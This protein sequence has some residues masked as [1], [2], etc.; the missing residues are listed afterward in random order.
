MKKKLNKEKLV[1]KEPCEMQFKLTVD[2]DT[3]FD[4]ISLIEADVF[5]SIVM[6]GRGIGKTENGNGFVL[7]E[8]KD[9]GEEFIYLR[10]YKSE[11]KGCDTLLDKWIDDVVT[12]P[13]GNGGGTF[14]WHQ[15]RLGWFIPLSIHTRYKSGYD[16]SKVKY[17]I[18]D[19][20]IIKPTATDRYLTDEVTQ[21]LEFIS[22]VFRH[23]TDG[24]VI[25][26]GNNLIFFNPYC[27]F[28]K[29][30]VFNGKYIDRAKGIQVLYSKDSSKLRAIE[31]NTPLF[32]LTKGT[33]YHDYH[34]NNA[35]MSNSKVSISEKN[36]NDKIEIRCILNS[37]TMNI[38]NRQQGRILIESK[39]KIYN[40]G[41]TYEMLEENNPNYLNIKYFKDMYYSLLFY[42]YFRNEIDYASQEAYN[43]FTE[44]MNLF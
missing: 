19:E 5:L 28:F 18:F 37:Y 10:R 13:D 8:F 41:I 11:L 3:Y 27:E 33:P 21:L 4:I 26:F 1:Y 42:K 2:C 32:K 31:E 7:N 43:L 38:Y 39:N 40:D 16:F 44:F 34:Y 22:T 15:N 9:F 12:I 35:V 20:A 29:V 30:K 25:I 36:N 24:K 23:R 6:G 14:N 17:I